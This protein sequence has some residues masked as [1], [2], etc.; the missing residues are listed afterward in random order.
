MAIRGR[1][2]SLDNVLEELI[3]T[4]KLRGKLDEVELHRFWEELLGPQINAQT[5]GLFLQGDKVMVRLSSSVL[6]AEL[7]MARTRLLE[8]INARFG[9]NRVKDLIFI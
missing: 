3:D 4:Y 1:A 2:Q 8:K 7:S 5:E 9:S 6:R